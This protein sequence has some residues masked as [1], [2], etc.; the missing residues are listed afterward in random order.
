MNRLVHIVRF[1][2][3]MV[4]AFQEAKEKADLDVQIK[5]AAKK[6]AKDAVG[7]GRKKGNTILAKV[8]LLLFPI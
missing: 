8:S 2:V 4:N 7:G 6:L 1:E 5:N 3:D